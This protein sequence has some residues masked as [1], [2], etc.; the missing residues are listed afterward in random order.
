MS[1][2]NHGVVGVKSTVFKNGKLKKPARHKNSR[3][4]T[5]QINQKHSAQ[6]VARIFDFYRSKINGNHIKGGFGTALKNRT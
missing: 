5:D 3:N 1:W 6:S 2:W 4:Y